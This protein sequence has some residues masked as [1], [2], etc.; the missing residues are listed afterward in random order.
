MRVPPGM[1]RDRDDLG[2]GSRCAAAAGQGPARL[3]SDARRIEVGKKIARL[4][5]PRRNHRKVERGRTTAVRG[6]TGAGGAQTNAGGHCG[7]TAKRG[8]AVKH[9]G[10]HGRVHFCLLAATSPAACELTP[11]T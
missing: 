5:P 9:G 6:P 7:K 10:G 4:R 8:K 3:V 1:A 11:F 2:A